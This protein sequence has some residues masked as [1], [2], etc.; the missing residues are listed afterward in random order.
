MAVRLPPAAGRGPPPPPPPPVPTGPKVELLELQRRAGN[1]AVSERLQA[2]LAAP[3][4][5]GPALA[6]EAALVQL[7]FRF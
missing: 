5:W 6:V 1:R 3:V 2:G 4:G 7:G